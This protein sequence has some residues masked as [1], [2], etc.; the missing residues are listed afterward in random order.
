MELKIDTQNKEIHNVTHNLGIARGLNYAYSLITDYLATTG[1]AT[2]EAEKDYQAGIIETGKLIQKTLIK[3]N[4]DL[5]F[6]RL[7]TLEE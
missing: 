2:T 4:N 7:N 6:T 5:G 3:L 1:E